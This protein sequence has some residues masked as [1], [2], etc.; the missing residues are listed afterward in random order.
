MLH[1][2]AELEFDA[3]RRDDFVAAFRWLEPLVRA[4]DGCLEYRG[5]LEVPTAIAAQSPP[6]PGVLTVI[7][8]WRDEAALTA[9]LA[10]PH[11]G[12]FGRRVQGI[13]IGRVIRLLRDIG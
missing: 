4:E 10:A 1:V 6:R 5:A 3:S 2:I 12:D 13:M 7:E 9:H 8:K 11:M